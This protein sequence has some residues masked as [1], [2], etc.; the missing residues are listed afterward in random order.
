MLGPCRATWRAALRRVEEEE[1]E[2]DSGGI[3]QTMVMTAGA[4]AGESLVR[5][6]PP[7]GGAAH[8]G[9]G[10]AAGGVGLF[11]GL[12][13]PLR[14]RRLPQAEGSA[15]TRSFTS[16]VSS[17]SFAGSTA[18][19]AATSSLLAM[20]SLARFTASTATSTPSFR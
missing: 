1:L 5:E 12:P 2:G 13:K 8:V 17:A 14:L 3:G 20:N 16:T 7:A 9:A 19:F 6:V 4:L 18:F 11:A 15:Q 10:R